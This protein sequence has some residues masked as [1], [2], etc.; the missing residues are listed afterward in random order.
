MH[1][2]FLNVKNI[3]YYLE[4]NHNKYVSHAQIFHNKEKNAKELTNIF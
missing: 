4:K 3:N 1:K 2:I